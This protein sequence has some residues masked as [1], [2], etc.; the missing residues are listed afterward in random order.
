MKSCKKWVG[1]GNEVPFEGK[2]IMKKRWTAKVFHNFHKYIPP[3]PR[4]L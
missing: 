4:H 3:P 1:E 2:K